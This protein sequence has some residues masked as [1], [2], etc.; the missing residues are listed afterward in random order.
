MRIL[1]AGESE[2]EYTAR[3]S[4]MFFKAMAGQDDGD[5]S[6]MERTVIRTVPRRT[7]CWTAWSRSRRAMRSCPSD[8]RASS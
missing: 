2:Q 4:R 3:G 6:L 8:L 1:G 7:S 5:L